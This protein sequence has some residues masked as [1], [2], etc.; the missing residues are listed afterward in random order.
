MLKGYRNDTCH[1]IWLLSLDI[2]EHRRLSAISI[3]RTSNLG[4]SHFL[5]IARSG[6]PNGIPAQSPRLS[7]KAGSYPGGTTQKSS[8]RNGD[9]CKSL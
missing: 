5:R 7:R 1:V 9:L 4:A 6:N 8:N 2:S 3:F